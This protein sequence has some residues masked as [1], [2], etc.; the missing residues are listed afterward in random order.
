M[1]FQIYCFRKKLIIIYLYVARSNAHA[2][3]LVGFKHEHYEKLC[4]LLIQKKKKLCNLHFK[5]LLL[6]NRTRSC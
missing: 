1:W 6:T 3:L 2:F 4:N 5:K